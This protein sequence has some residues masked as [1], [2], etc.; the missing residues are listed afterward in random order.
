M[1]C[2]DRKKSN[3]KL[4]A[5]WDAITASIDIQRSNG[6][7]FRSLLFSLSLRFAHRRTTS[8]VTF[9]AYFMFRNLADFYVFPPRTDPNVNQK[10]SIYQVSVA[11][12][13]LQY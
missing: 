4:L 7:F 13:A 12:G 8:C 10:K 5:D 2:F 11:L 9:F 1:K 6:V 3:M